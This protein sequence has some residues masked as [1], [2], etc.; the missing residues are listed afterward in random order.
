[1]ND[2]FHVHWAIFLS[3]AA[4]IFFFPVSHSTYSLPSQFSEKELSRW[5]YLASE[6]SSNPNKKIILN[7]DGEGGRV[8]M[9]AAFMY[10]M[11]TW[12][13]EGKEIVLNIKSWAASSHALLVCY[14]DKVQL[15]EGATIYFHFYSSPGLDGKK[16]YSVAPGEQ[17]NPFMNALYR[18]VDKHLLTMDDVMAITVDHK[19]VEITKVNGKIMKSTV[20]DTP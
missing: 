17:D 5:N 20:E 16:D 12:R 4:L 18:C 2:W 6:I 19:A 3:I 10:N 14:A 1:M 13:N 11:M 15:A 7:A 9:A 8:L